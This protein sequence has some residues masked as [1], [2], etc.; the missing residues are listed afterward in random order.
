MTKLASFSLT[1]ERLWQFSLQYYNVRGVKEACLSLQNNYHGNVNL[2]LLLKWLDEQELIFDE[3]DWTKIQHCLHRTEELI[4]HFRTLRKKAKSHL[5]ATLYRES[6]EFELL[7]EKQ[8]QS[9][10]VN[11]INSIEFSTNKTEPLTLRYCRSLNA[12]HLF[13]NF[14]KPSS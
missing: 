3:H 14:P 8:Q 13:N 6:L 9:D 7:L 1:L 12:E 4:L 2:L 5:P 11:C 10:L